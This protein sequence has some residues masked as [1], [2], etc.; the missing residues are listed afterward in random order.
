[1]FGCYT[2]IAKD[3]AW[4]KNRFLHQKKSAN[5]AENVTETPKEA[6]DDVKPETTVYGAIGHRGGFGVGQK[7]ENLTKKIKPKKR[8]LSWKT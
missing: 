5:G 6:Q 1:V 8:D 4:S 2:K 7:S 3:H